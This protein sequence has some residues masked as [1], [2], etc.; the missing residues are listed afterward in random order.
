VDLAES[1]TDAQYWAHRHASAEVSKEEVAMPEGTIA[2][3][4]P[5]GP[6]GKLERQPEMPASSLETSAPLQHRSRYIDDRQHGVWS[7][8]WDSTPVTST[9]YRYPFCELMLVQE[10][11]VTIAETTGRETTIRAGGS[12]VFPLGL[13]CKWKQTEYFKKYSFGFRDPAAQQPSDNA[14]L[15]LVLPD[16]RGELDDTASPPA[17]LL[18]SP[19][20]L[21]RAH[22]WYADVTEQFSVG[23]WDTTAYQSRPAP[24]PRHEWNHVLE[25]SVTLTDEAGRAHNFAA[26]DTFVVP[27]GAVCGWSC[28]KYLRTLYGT[29]RPKAE[30]TIA[31][32]AE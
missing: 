4:A 8:V 19:V 11:S 26:G 20:P 13:V 30:A 10:G 12:F 17:E 31:R 14:T 29:F 23:V 9:F 32:A 16:P 18:L 15:Q 27:F 5:L 3:F 25:G 24:S 21:Q 22:E 28:S 2:R 7:S 6:T 1:V